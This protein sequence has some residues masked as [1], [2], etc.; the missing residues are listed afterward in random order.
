MIATFLL[1]PLA[2][3]RMVESLLSAIAILFNALT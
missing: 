2:M 1:D 3:H